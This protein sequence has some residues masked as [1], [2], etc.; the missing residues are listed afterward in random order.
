[1]LRYVLSV[2]FQFRSCIWKYLPVTSM[3]EMSNEKS[4]AEKRII[5]PWLCDRKW[6]NDNELYSDVQFSI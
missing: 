6:A 2:P 4:T 3:C 1:M 5:S